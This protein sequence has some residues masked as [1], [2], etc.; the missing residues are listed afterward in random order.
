MHQKDRRWDIKAITGEGETT[1]KTGF[2]SIPAKGYHKEKVW[3]T[4]STA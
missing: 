3:T 2:K 1:E 4:H